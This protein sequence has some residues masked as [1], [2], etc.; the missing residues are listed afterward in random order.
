MTSPPLL[1]VVMYHYVRDLPRTPWPRLKAMLLDDFRQQIALLRQQYE[2]AT[3]ASALDYLEGWYCPERPL[4][5]LT[6]DDALKEHYRDVT[7]ILRDAGIQGLFMLQTSALAGRVA[8]VH[9]NHFLLASLP[10]EQYQRSFLSRAVA[11]HSDISLDVD[12][13]DV[14]RTYRWDTADVARFKYLLNF[15]IPE[16]VRER[17]L[18][19]LFAEHLGDEREFARDL[20]LQWNEA[21]EMQSAGMMIGGHSHS[22]MAL[23]RM[24]EEAVRADLITCATALHAHL[25]PQEFWPFSYPYGR[26]N[27]TADPILR[28]LG[29][30]CSFTTE[31]GHNAPDA[32]LFRIRRIDPKD[33]ALTSPRAVAFN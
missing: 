4:C 32:D 15:R 7:P 6:F 29:F 2:M 1:T 11:E 10:F 13:R 26:V 31:V 5:L 20:Y 33:V 21:R 8:A 9:K 27:E 14:S 17:I 30:S 18:D 23:T 25:Q 22:H 19:D 24:D 28:Q 12:A 3:L 16:D